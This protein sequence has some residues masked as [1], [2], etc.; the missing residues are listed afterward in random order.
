MSQAVNEWTNTV[1]SNNCEAT[2]PSCKQITVELNVY[3]TITK[4]TNFFH[5]EASG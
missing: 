4:G 5:T 3:K 1:Y 2:G